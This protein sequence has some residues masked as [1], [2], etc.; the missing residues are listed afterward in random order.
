MGILSFKN[1]WVQNGGLSGH[2]ATWTVSFVLSFIVYIFSIVIMKSASGDMEKCFGLFSWFFLNFF[3][4]S[5]L[6]FSSSLAYRYWNQPTRLNRNLAANS[7]NLY[8]AHYIFVLVWQLLLF[9][10]LTM[11][12]FLKFALVS[13]SS[14]Y[15]GYNVSRFLIRPWPKLSI[16][17]VILVFTAMI[18]FIN[19]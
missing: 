19:P 7:Y 6:G 9:R 18:I 10:F 12:V 1:S 14:V 13:V 5:T 16:V 8:L 3:T 11:P 4:I 17:V 15:C 2:Q